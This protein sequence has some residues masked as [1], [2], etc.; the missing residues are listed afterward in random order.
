MKTSWPYF[1]LLDLSWALSSCCSHIQVQRWRWMD[2]NDARGGFMRRKTSEKILQLAAFDKM[3]CPPRAEK[4]FIL[5]LYR[6]IISSA[7]LPKSQRLRGSFWRDS[8]PFSHRFELCSRVNNLRYRHISKTHIVSCDC[9]R[10]GN[11]QGEPD[12]CQLRDMTLL[13][14]QRQS[15]KVRESEQRRVS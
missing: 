10:L 9:P 11:V 7:V 8:C 5:A 1:F 4:G 15:R 2:E 13:G 12:S 6:T 3:K 14:S